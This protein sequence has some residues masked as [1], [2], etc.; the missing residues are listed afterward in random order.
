M[1]R[2]LQ[3]LFDNV[4]SRVVVQGYASRTLV[5]QVGILQ[6]SILC[7]ILYATFID[8]LPARLRSISTCRMG[9]TQL[10]SFFYADDIAI[11]ADDAG[12][13]ARY[14]G[15]CESF[16][17]ESC[18]RFQPIK[19]EIVANCNTESCTLYGAPLKRS[20]SF[21]Y[22]GMTL[23]INGINAMGHVT[24]TCSKT[25]DATNILRM[26]GYNGHGFATKVKKRLYETFIRPRLEY[27]LQLIQPQGKVLK[28]LEQTQHGALCAMFSVNRRTSATKLRTY[29]GIHS[30]LQRCHELNGTCVQAV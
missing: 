25:T 5:H 24:R 22:L 7:P 12:Q 11:I 18:F 26:I 3:A 1:P 23:D 2:T 10:A 19:C 8:E 13:M 6:G 4:T 17:L 9:N 28:L 27:G 15:E 30:M 20:T 29:S 16:S 21:V 14:L